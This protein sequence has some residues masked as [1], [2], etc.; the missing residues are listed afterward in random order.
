MY[1]SSQVKRNVI[2]KIDLPGDGETP[3]VLYRKSERAFVFE[4]V[5]ELSEP[6][7]F[8]DELTNE[9]SRVIADLGSGD[10]TLRFELTY[11][12]T[13]SQTELA[14]MFSRLQAKLGDGNS[15]NLRIVW[16]RCEERST[17]RAFNHL[18]KYV[19]SLGSP[20]IPFESEP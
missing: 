16:Q 7:D 2:D 5:S 12:R 18:Q 1:R 19:E 20:T 3:A 13:N 6:K 10:L 4:G 8:Y 9:I 14:R 17:E 15:V 11:V